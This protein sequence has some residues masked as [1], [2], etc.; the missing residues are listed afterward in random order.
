MEL[1]EREPEQVS[2]FVQRRIDALLAH[3]TEHSKWWRNHL[4]L[5]QDVNFTD[6]PLLNRGSYRA[7]IEDAGGPLPL[8]QSYGPTSKQTTSGSSGVRFNSTHRIWSAECRMS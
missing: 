3:V 8:P 5:D 2:S 7:S 4:E 1:F 6:L